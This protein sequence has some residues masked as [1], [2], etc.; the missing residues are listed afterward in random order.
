MI[1]FVSGKNHN[2][3]HTAEIIVSV[4][5]THVEMI[6]YVWCVD[7]SAF[8]GYNIVTVKNFR[9]NV[10][11]LGV[12]YDDGSAFQVFRHYHRFGSVGGGYYKIGFFYGSDLA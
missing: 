7:K 8:N 4:F 2:F 3:S 1:M 5:K 12:V 6:F 9:R 11:R 10:R